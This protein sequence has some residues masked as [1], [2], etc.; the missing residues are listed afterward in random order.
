MLIYSFRI[1]LFGFN[2]CYSPKLVG[3]NR[4]EIINENSKTVVAIEGDVISSA[5]FYS[6]YTY[7]IEKGVLKIGVSYTLFKPLST[8]SSKFFIKIES[9]ENIDTVY[10]T[11]N[12]IE[13]I[14]YSS[15]K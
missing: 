2:A 8:G 7:K 12:K 6:D 1:N 3:I 11:N 5:L 10:I 14:I 4:I 9:Q 13:K 15:V